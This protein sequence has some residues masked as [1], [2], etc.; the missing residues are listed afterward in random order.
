[1]RGAPVLEART[2]GKIKLVKWKGPMWFRV[3]IN[4][5]SSVSDGLEGG[6]INNQGS[7]I[8]GWSFCLD[9]LN[10][11]VERLLLSTSNN[12]QPSMVLCNNS[13]SFSS[14]AI[15]GTS[16][17]QDGLSLDLIFKVS[18]DFVSFGVESKILV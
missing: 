9:L 15:P 6:E 4:F 10:G 16:G 13:C 17:D 8:G 11:I 1:M 7:Q 2:L 12:D 5:S 18:S 14:K 3:S